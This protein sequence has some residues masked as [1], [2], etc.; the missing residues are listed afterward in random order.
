MTVRCDSAFARYAE[1]MPYYTIS[2]KNPM[3]ILFAR[4]AEIMP[5]YTMDVG[6]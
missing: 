6:L 4:Y 5:Y 3:G 1:I 2:T